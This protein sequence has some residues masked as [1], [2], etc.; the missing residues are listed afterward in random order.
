MDLSGL[1]WTFL[2]KKALDGFL[3]SGGLASES[4]IQ[5]QRVGEI[6]NANNQPMGSIKAEMRS[7]FRV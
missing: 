1:E 2:V 7:G 4:R 3:L 5:N 6:G